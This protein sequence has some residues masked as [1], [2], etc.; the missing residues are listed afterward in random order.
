MSNAC[1]QQRYEQ[2]ISEQLAKDNPHSEQ[3]RRDWGIAIAKLADL[4][5]SLGKLESAQQRYEQRLAISERSTAIL[6]RAT[7]RKT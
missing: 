4:E 6:R 2:R 5:K 3:L 7:P 1:A